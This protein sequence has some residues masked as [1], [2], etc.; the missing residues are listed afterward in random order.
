VS[1][2]WPIKLYRSHAPKLYI[3]PEI[4]KTLPNSAA[5]PH[6]PCN[7]KIEMPTERQI[8]ASRVNGAK[9]RGPVTPEG[10]RNSSANAIKHGLLA[11]TVVL[12]GELEERF[13]EVIA[14]IDQELQPETPI[15]HALVEKMAVARW[16]Q[17]RLWG[18]E[19]AAMEYQ[20]RQQAGSVGRGESN[21]TRASL[22]FQTLGGD[23]RS[24]DLIIRYDALCDRQYLRAHKRFLDTRKIE[25][26]NDTRRRAESPAPAA[27]KPTFE[28]EPEPQPENS[29][30]PEFSSGP[31]WDPFIPEPS[32]PAEPNENQPNEPNN[33]LKTLEPAAAAAT[34][35]ASCP[36][37][38]QPLPKPAPRS[39]PRYRRVPRVDPNRLIMI[40]PEIKPQ[41]RT[42]T[43]HF[44]PR[45]ALLSLRNK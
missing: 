44:A 34:P 29:T 30:E 45:R 16:R 10:K 3:S 18:M 39:R 35:P 2:S 17:L 37:R 12:K 5:I 14:E 1:I 9:S 41:R 26:H 43:K 42:A 33:P 27:S 20:I 22:A 31:V 13:L 23:A 8:E 40:E 19:K 25:I 21:A 11:E 38:R 24:L 28:P 4:N 7:N 6:H 15:E 32:S 36:G